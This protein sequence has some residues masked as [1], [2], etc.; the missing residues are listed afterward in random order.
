MQLYIEQAQVRYDAKK[1]L[2]PRLFQVHRTAGAKKSWLA[3]NLAPVSAPTS[4]GDETDCHG[5][6]YKGL[7]RAADGPRAGAGFIGP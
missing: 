1:L 2:A 4:D 6:V 7:N 5:Y 3:W